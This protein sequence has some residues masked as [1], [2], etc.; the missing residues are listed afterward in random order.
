M[1]RV[2]MVAILLWVSV[3]WSVARGE[4]AE[5]DKSSPFG[6]GF[7]QFGGIAVR[8][9]E[10]KPYFQVKKVNQ[11]W[12]LVTPEGHAFWML[13]VFNTTPAG[14]IDDLKDS[15]LNRVRRKYGDLS[16]WGIQTVRRLR[17]WGFNTTAEYSTY[18]VRPTKPPYGGTVGNPERMAFTLI[19]RPSYYALLNQGKYAPAAVKDIIAGTD[20]AIYTG[21]R[22]NG[23]P[24]VFDPNFEAYV[25][26]M[27]Q[28]SKELVAGLGSPWL[29]GIATDDSDNIVGFGPGPEIPASRIHPH[30]GWL[31]L[32]SSF[33]QTSNAKL[34]VDYPDQKLYTK[35][36][37]RDMLRAKYQTVGAL[38][39]AWGSSY[40]TFDSDGGWPQGKGLLDES[41]RSAWVGKDP[42]RLSKAAPRVVGDLDEFLYVY[43]KQ[44]FSVTAGRI[45]AHAQNALVFGPATLNGWGGLTRKEVLRAA[46][47]YVDVVQASTRNQT[48]LDATVKYIGD[49]PLMGW[50]G[51][52]ANA[53]SALWRYPYKQEVTPVLT[54]QEE[55]GRTYQTRVTN[56]F[57]ASTS[58]GVKPIIGIKLWSLTD[59]W[60]EKGNWG[61]VSFLDNPYDGKAAVR[62]EGKDPWGYPTGGE[63]RDYG[64]F[65][66]AVR[67][68][69]AFVT[70]RLR[71][72][73]EQAGAR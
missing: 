38:N 32:A 26:A 13:G 46:A 51:M 44:Y 63:E 15:H 49:K 34:K 7:D 2:L 58:S 65:I 27:M 6:P 45:R 4:G 55:R 69:H 54:T 52:V 1:T 47:E 30:I 17:G 33:E 41:G 48:Q 29:I 37:L 70:Q 71:Q 3:W 60:G 12:V 25:D 68:T 53:D 35:Y 64:D 40:T 8:V 73:L 19:I 66:T 23:T 50:T 59:S 39:A 36:A 14:S 9:T 11:R 67:Q 62:A 21:W 16:V 72:E 20:P 43:A 22:G 10:P 56:D 31:V 24:D 18:Y 5:A 28:K 61:L 42:E 57:T